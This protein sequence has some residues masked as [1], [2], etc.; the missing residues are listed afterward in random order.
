[1][2]GY[3]SWAKTNLHAELLSQIVTVIF[4]LYAFTRALFW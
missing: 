2:N 4:V 3:V 1:M